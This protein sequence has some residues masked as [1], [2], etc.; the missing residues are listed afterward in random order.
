MTATEV[1]KH[2]HK[3]ILKV[4]EAVRSEARTM[5]E[6]GSLDAPKLEKIL[7]FCRVFVDRCHQGKEEEYLFPLLLQRG[8]PPDSG[9]VPV[10]LQEH[11]G[12]RNAVQAISEARRPG[13]GSGNI[14]VRLAPGPAGFVEATVRDDGPGV[15]P[16]RMEKLFV[17]FY[18][19]RQKGVGLGLYIVHS[20]MERQGGRVELE[21]AKEGGLI[22]RLLF[23]TGNR[24]D[25]KD[26][27]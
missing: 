21:N 7:D 14:A 27:R 26:E 20:L 11:Q 4:M 16:D 15:P 17:P 13:R 25:G 18:T 10:L 9:P 6:F 3:I 8:L 23:A 19:E 2:E 24:G 12:G 5:A 1:L 22:V